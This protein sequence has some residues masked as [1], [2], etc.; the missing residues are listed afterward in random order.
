[1]V[2]RQG[3]GSVTLQ[4]EI[5]KDWDSSHASHVRSNLVS[6]RLVV[7]QASVRPPRHAHFHPMCA[8]ALWQPIRDVPALRLHLLS[9][10]V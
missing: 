5:I 9:C 8:Q 7:A 1:L 6:W 10:H 4:P 3:R 2:L